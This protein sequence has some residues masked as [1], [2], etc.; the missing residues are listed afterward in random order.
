MG[1]IFQDVGIVGKARKQVIN[2]ESIP[3]CR[4]MFQLA[5]SD[6]GSHPLMGNVL[7]T[8]WPP[9]RV[10]LWFKSDE[11]KAVYLYYASTITFHKTVSQVYLT[12]LPDVNMTESLLYTFKWNIEK[13]WWNKIPHFA[14]FLSK[15]NIFTDYLPDY[16]LLIF[17]SINII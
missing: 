11:W 6:V 10:C 8:L 5:V 17:I 13:Y 14:Y 4:K 16:F 7:S 2:N 12:S 1:K 3:N 15:L 9:L